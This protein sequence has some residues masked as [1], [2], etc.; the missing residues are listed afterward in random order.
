MKRA[1]KRRPK[2]TKW[3]RQS[4]EGERTVS[5]ALLKFR[6]TIR[7]EMDVVRASLTPS[8]MAG[9][10]RE[11]STRISV[12]GMILSTTFGFTTEFVQKV[13]EEEMGSMS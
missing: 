5:E 11:A 8:L 3:V 2:V 12:E 4:E 10:I 1:R 13:M 7:R 6:R 9:A